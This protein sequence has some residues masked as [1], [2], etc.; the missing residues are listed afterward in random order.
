MK[1]F[2]MTKLVYAT[3]RQRVWSEDPTQ[4]GPL[5]VLEVPQESILDATTEPAKASLAPLQVNGSPAMPENP[6]WLLA[7]PSAGLP[8]EAVRVVTLAMQLGLAWA[9]VLDGQNRPVWVCLN[10]AYKR[11][12][13]VSPSEAMAKA[14]SVPPPASESM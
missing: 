2:A 5:Y 4:P 13:L 9:H 3:T 10:D 11:A 7:R 12:R 6:S 8:E 1:E 14:K